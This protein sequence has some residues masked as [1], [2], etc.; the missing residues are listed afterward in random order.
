MRE[1]RGG[2][3]GKMGV[4]LTPE[5]GREREMGVELIPKGK[6]ERGRLEWGLLTRY[7]DS[8]GSSE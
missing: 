1:E 7:K 4:K 2:A 6:R 5:G 3:E 8:K